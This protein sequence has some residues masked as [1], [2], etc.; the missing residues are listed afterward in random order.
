MHGRLRPGLRLVLLRQHSMRVSAAHAQVNALWWQTGRQPGR[1]V[2]RL[3]VCLMWRFARRGLLFRLN[4][5]QTVAK[6]FRAFGFERPWSDLLS[7]VSA[8]RVS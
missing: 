5:A 8:L 1:P 3:D 6:S 2:L 4:V 7:V